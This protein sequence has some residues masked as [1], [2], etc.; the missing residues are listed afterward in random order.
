MSTF[1]KIKALR[2]SLSSSEA[3]LADFTLNSANAIRNLSSVEL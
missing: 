2:Q 1:V 3:K